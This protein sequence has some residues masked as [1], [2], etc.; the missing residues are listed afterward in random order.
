MCVCFSVILCVI[1]VVFQGE[2]GPPSLEYIQA[3]DLFPQ[4]ELV[5]EDDSLQVS[6][7]PSHHTMHWNDQNRN[8]GHTHKAEPQKVHMHSVCASKEIV[9]AFFYLF[10]YFNWACCHV[11][12]WF[13]KPLVERSLGVVSPLYTWR[14]QWLQIACLKPFIESVN[15]FH[16][17][18]HRL[19][20]LFL[21][22][23]YYFLIFID[24]RYQM[25]AKC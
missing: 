15:W 10:I 13:I 7:S 24:L 5:K 23:F 19:F 2:E 21:F 18:L 11:L 16:L 14:E 1:I 25:F 12:K 4:K 17:L 9:H 8:S 3:K 20:F 6:C 22:L